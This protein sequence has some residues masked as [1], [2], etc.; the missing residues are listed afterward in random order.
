MIDD[1][2]NDDNNDTPVI[3]NDTR[4][5]PTRS[6][7]RLPAAK[8]VS[9]NEIVNMLLLATWPLVGKINFL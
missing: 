3:K 9:P 2:G 8:D 6:P 7:N 4:R 5:R 1:S